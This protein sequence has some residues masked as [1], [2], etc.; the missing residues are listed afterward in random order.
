MKVKLIK[1][2]DE[3][4]CGAA[5][6]SMILEFYG[7]K[8]PLASVREA[9]KVDQHGAN[10][11]GM[12]DGA[13]K[14]DLIGSPFDLYD[15]QNQFSP[16]EV[17]DL[18]AGREVNFPF[19][20]RIVNKS[21]YEHFIVIENATTEGLAVCDPGE[22]KIHMGHD[23]FLACFPGQVIPGTWPCPA[24]SPP[25]VDWPCGKGCSRPPPGP[26]R[27]SPAAR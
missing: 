22:G 13:D 9:I 20:A 7:K 2:H 4:D 16:S 24:R 6:L 18:I 10:I 17:W 8:V 12:V 11:Y 21:G 26:C 25:A 14:F 3:K 27:R 1:Q 23:Q 19:I 15:D 5:C